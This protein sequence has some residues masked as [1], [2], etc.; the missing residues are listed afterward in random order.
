M[1]CVDL[2]PADRCQHREEEA[3]KD[4]QSGSS[5]HGHCRCPFTEHLTQD[6]SQQVGVSPRPRG[7]S[8]PSSFVI[9]LSVC[10]SAPRS[11]IR[12]ER[13]H[14]LSIPL[15]S[16]APGKRPSWGG[17]EGT[18]ARSDPCL[19]IWPPSGEASIHLQETET[20]NLSTI[21]LFNNILFWSSIECI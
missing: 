8:Q 14:F 7:H 20:D 2:S 9:L 15:Y 11:D 10:L 17:G 19:Q 13:S 21:A 4:R 6:C 18:G 1:V 5:C 12:L 3:A 16:T